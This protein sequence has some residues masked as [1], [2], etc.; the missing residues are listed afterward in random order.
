MFLKRHAVIPKLS[1][2]FPKRRSNLIKNWTPSR[3]CTRCAIIRDTLSFQL[4]ILFFAILLRN[5]GRKSSSVFQA[6]KLKLEMDSLI[7]FRPTVS[8]ALQL[9]L[10][11]RLEWKT[12]ISEIETQRSWTFFSL[13]MKN[14]LQFD[15]DNFECY[16]YVAELEI[17][18]RDETCCQRVGTYKI[19]NS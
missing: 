2:Q 12:C 19:C 7:N 1:K 5:G 4:W 15:D 16:R 11:W 6:A 8:L 17:R 13:S 10:E 9:P 3:A 14:I 18:M